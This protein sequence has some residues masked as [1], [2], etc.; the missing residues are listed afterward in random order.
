MAWTAV[1]LAH[2]EAGLWLL[3]HPRPGYFGI[4]GI[5]W[6]GPPFASPIPKPA[7][8]C[9]FTHAHLKGAWRQIEVCD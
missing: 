1:R 7:Y 2:P 3:L 4:S 8:G 9:Y 6:P 5:P